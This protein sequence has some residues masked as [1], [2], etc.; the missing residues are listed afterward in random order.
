M[1]SKQMTQQLSKLCRKLENR[2]YGRMKKES[3]ENGIKVAK[4]AT[5]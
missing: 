5:L 2:C 1:D 3:K 4:D